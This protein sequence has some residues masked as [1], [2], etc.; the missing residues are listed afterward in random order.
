MIRERG[1]GKNMQIIFLTEDGYN[2]AITIDS[3]CARMLWR[4]LDNMINK[5][6]L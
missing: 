6:E 2:M 3:F 1:Q 4:N 5:G